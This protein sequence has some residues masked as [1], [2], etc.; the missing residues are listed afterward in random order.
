MKIINKFLPAV[1]FFIE[2]IVQALKTQDY[3]LPPPPLLAV[4]PLPV[5]TRTKQTFYNKSS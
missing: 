1:C 4:D 2:A 5:T 3:A